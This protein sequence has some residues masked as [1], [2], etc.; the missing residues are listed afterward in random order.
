M[1]IQR[2]LS[3]AAVLSELGQRIART[4]LER[5]ISQAQLAE[6]AGVALPTVQRLEAG[7]SVAVTNLV[8]V[9]RALDLLHGLERAVPEPLPSPIEQLK[10]QG[11]RRQRA[12]RPRGAQQQEEGEPWRWGDGDASET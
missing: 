1:K 5:N 7:H 4:R 6:Q 2:E 3:D 10:L 9:L 8:R 11:R 12:G